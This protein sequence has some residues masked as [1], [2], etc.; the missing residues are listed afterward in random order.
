MGRPPRNFHSEGSSKAVL[1]GGFSKGVQQGRSHKGLCPGGSSMGVITW[2]FPQR[3][4]HRWLPQGAEGVP[5]GSPS[6]GA[7]WFP[8]SVFPEAVPQ[9]RSLNFGPARGIAKK[10]PHWRFTE[11][12]PIK[13]FQQGSLKGVPQGGTSNCGP[14]SGTPRVV[15][16]EDAARGVPQGVPKTASPESGTPRRTRKGVPVTDVLQTRN[17]RG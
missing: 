16:Q 10:R 15:P 3:W 7:K 6:E 12:F 11:R 9:S 13:W 17:K 1:Q 4:S 14:E 8:Q 5:K 2:A